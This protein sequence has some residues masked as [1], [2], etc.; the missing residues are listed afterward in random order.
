MR[1]ENLEKFT[2]ASLINRMKWLREAPS[3]DVAT[4]IKMILS[5]ALYDEFKDDPEYQRRA[6]LGASL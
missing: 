6:S 4:V 2:E 3:N 1:F 5:Q